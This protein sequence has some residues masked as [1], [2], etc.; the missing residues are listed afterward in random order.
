[1]KVDGAIFPGRDDLSLYESDLSSVPARARLLEQQGFDGLFTLDTS[2]DPFF[3]LLLAAEH[4]ERIELVTAVA[5]AFA[6]TPMTMALP[7]WNLQKLSGGR[8]VLGLGSQV[9]AHVEKRFGMPWHGPARQMREFVLA[10][11]AIWH[12]WQTGEPLRFRGELYTHSLMNPLFDPGPI[13]VPPP[14][15]VVGALGPQMVRVAGEV[16]D[17]L[18]GHPFTTS[19]F[20]REVQL[21]ALREGL[22]A[23]GRTLADFD[24]PAMLL[25][26]T[27]RDARERAVAE[28]AARRLLAF[29]GSTPAYYCVLEQHGF[30]DLGPR[31]NRMSKE[32]RWAEMSAL[33]PD[34]LLR[35]ICLVGTPDE[36]PELARERCRGGCD[37]ITLYAPY[38]SS[39]ETWPSIVRGIQ[40]IPVEGR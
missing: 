27:G 26:V 28:G 22:S 21:P 12:A 16:A 32:G 39:P 30:D 24:M 5:I 20:V 38:P 25:T 35:E 23:S 13:D 10:L 40:R 8:L 36:I 18:Y 33:L 1:M 29:Y 19:A 6:R 11:R 4:S 31:L 14:R 7:A 34:E 3:T 37:R 2:I 15:V 17:G 9:R